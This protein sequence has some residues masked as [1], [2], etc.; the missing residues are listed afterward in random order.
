MELKSMN[1]YFNI[2]LWNLRACIYKISLGNHFSFIN[3]F[4]QIHLQSDSI[5]VQRRVNSHKY[6]QMYILSVY[7]LS[8]KF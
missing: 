8:H 1:F 2:D 7:Y 6:G 4:W 5:P 3:G